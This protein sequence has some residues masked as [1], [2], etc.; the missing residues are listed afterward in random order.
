[1]GQVMG[2]EQLESA[3][4][5][6]EPGCVDCM[7]LMSIL[8]SLCEFQASLVTQQ[9]SGQSGLQQHHTIQH[10]TAKHKK[11]EPGLCKHNSTSFLLCTQ[12]PGPA[13]RHV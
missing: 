12:Q 6:L 3:H 4:K 2:R 5:K 1:M 8:G 9:V 10:N 11:M 7:P 13:R